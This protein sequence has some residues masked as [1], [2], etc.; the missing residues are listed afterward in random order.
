MGFNM[1]FVLIGPQKTTLL[2]I[3][4]GLKKTDPQYRFESGEYFL[5]GNDLLGQV[6]EYRTGETLFQSQLEWLKHRAGSQDK[7]AKEPV[8]QALEQA[9]SILFFQVL[10]EELSD[11]ETL[12]LYSPLWDWLFA[13]R[14]G[15]LYVDAEGFWD[16]RGLLLPEE[17]R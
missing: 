5:H 3:A 13:H 11:D 7:P 4:R 9:S 17:S 10:S 12:A 1:Q 6:E 15:L 14:A 2:Q 16:A 8:L